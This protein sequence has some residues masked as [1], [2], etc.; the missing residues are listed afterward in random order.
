LEAAEAA[1]PSLAV[2]TPG[3]RGMRRVEGSVA[4]RGPYPEFITR[5]RG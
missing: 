3:N 1:K 4:F 2:V 5:A